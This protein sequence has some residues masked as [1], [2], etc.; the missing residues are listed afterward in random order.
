MQTFE[1]FNT[2]IDINKRLDYNFWSP[3]DKV[4]VS[5]NVQVKKL[6]SWIG[7]GNL[8]ASAFYPSITPFYQRKDEDKDL[9]PFIRVEDTRKLLLSY[10]NTVFLNRDLLDS[11]SSNIKRVISGDV[12]IT[13]GG[14]YIG[15]A[16]L[17]PNYY[18]EY[19]I[20]RDVL[21]IRT[22]E[23][24]ISGEYL[25]SYFQ[26]NYGKEDL[27]R[28]RSVQGQPHLTLDKIYDLAIPYYGEDFEAEIKEFWESFYVLLGESNAHLEN[29]KRLLNE[30]LF[31]KLNIKEELDTFQK[32]LSLSHIKNRIDFDY[33]HNRW[34]ILVNE[35]KSLGIKFEK[36][37][38]IKKAIDYSEPQ[39]LYKYIT[40]ADIDDRSGIIKHYR[41]IPVHSL[42]DRAKRAVVC[43][44]VLVSS[45]KG[46]K[47]KIALIENDFDN[48]VASTGFYVVRSDNIKPEVLYVIFRSKFYDLFI[49]QM[50]S[51]SIM[52]SIIETYFKK[53]ELPIVDSVGQDKISDEV[54]NYLSKRAV[55]FE[56]L[57]QAALKFDIENGSE[58]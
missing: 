19:A 31:S 4:G 53:L 16:S 10:D 3:R 48:M 55:A 47:E 42:P 56:N 8:I 9:L 25:T 44:D 12:L 54:C 21:A 45:L 22:S 58:F 34:S 28:T 24:T 38:H 27:V 23:S 18:P 17:V 14:E 20:C 7:T 2:E 13:K 5:D 40:L 11:L 46:S 41:E 52:S 51:G 39:K 15:E 6:R 49:E 35:L 32:E 1:V 29:A 30:S 26:S 50:A 37:Q 36:V 57:E 33:Y 43:K